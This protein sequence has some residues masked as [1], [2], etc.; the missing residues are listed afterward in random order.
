LLYFLPI[1][2]AISLYEIGEIHWCDTLAE[3]QKIT[4]SDNGLEMFGRE[5]SHPDQ[6][7]SI[8]TH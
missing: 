3:I 6:D 2:Q 5:S 4:S 7:S 1:F 8:E